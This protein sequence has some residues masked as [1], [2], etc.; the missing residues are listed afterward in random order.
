MGTLDYIP[1]ILF[2][3]DLDEVNIFI[4]SAL[5]LIFSIKP[6]RVAD[7]AANRL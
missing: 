5:R 3:Q 2:N 6:K 7:Q 1:S 4:Q